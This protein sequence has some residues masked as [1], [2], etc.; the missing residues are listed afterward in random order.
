M[1]ILQC[2]NLL[3]CTDTRIL[4]LAFPQFI[5]LR[6]YF[7]SDIF[8]YTGNRAR[9]RKRKR[10]EVVARKGFILPLSINR[11]VALV[12]LRKWGSQLSRFPSPPLLIINSLREIGPCIADRLGS[13]EAILIAENVL[14][15]L[16]DLIAIRSINSWVASVVGLVAEWLRHP[17]SNLETRVQF[18]AK[19]HFHS[20]V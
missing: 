1:Q 2:W 3:N 12:I 20:F 8:F 10:K 7:T 5:P 11:S 9:R 13:T 15:C 6:F 16:P 14:Y 18:P 17:T 4:L 19:P